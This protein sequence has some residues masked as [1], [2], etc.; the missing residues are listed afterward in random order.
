MAHAHAWLHS[1]VTVVVVLAVVKLAKGG[2]LGTSVA[3][4]ANQIV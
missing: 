1:F 2:T 4:F 3:S